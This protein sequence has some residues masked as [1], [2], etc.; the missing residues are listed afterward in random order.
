MLPIPALFITAYLVCIVLKIISYYQINSEVYQIAERIRKISTNDNYRDLFASHEIDT[1]NLELIAQNKD[2]L[3]KL[4][5]F[6]HFMYFLAAPTLCYQLQY[7]RNNSIR[8]VWLL[9]RCV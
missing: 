3:M 6:R 2:N 9:K 7:P 5:S 4:L 8:R 1:T